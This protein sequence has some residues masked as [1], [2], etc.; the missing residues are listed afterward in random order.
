MRCQCCKKQPAVV[1][2]RDLDGWRTTAAVA[3][4]ASCAQEA[5]AAVSDPLVPAPAI[6]ESARESKGT[7]GGASILDDDLTAELE[8]AL[9]ETPAPTVTCPTCAMTFDEFKKEG[10][11]GCAA[12][13]DTFG[14]PLIEAIRRIHGIP[15]AKHT[16]M[17][18]GASAPSRAI[19]VKQDLQRLS[20]LMQAAVEAE[21]YERAA[22]LRDEI[23]VL[24]KEVKA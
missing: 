15:E 9:S 19:A 18:P 5:A 10:R 2:I 6:L 1:E 16:G 22:K 12:C 24:E 17:R 13:Y 8:K 7:A 23:H 14:G 20:R 21:N 4:C 11:L 3:L